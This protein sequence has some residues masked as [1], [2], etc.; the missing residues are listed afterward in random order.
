MK[1]LPKYLLTATDLDLTGFIE[2]IVEQITGVEAAQ[3]TAAGFLTIQKPGKKGKNELFLKNLDGRET[4]I[5]VQGKGKGTRVGKFI[6]DTD[7]ME[8]ALLD[9]IGFTA[10]VD[11]YV[12]NEIGPVQTISRNFSTAAKMLLTNDR[13]AVLATV[14]KTGR[15]FVRE[16]K[17]TVGV[18]F[19]EV[20]EDNQAAL[21]EQILK[22]YLSAFAMRAREQAQE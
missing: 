11:L 9:A 12:I 1:A 17:R 19:L 5:G 4:K 7:A 2:R 8:E 16:V 13:V 14:S 21:E 6:L 10:G 20:N 22:D 18:N 3:I 15:G